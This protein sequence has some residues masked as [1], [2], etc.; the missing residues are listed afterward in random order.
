[1]WS[2]LYVKQESNELTQV[3]GK[4]EQLF[5]GNLAYDLVRFDV[6]HLRNELIALQRSVEERRDVILNLGSE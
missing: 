6:Y 1:M 4:P 2:D 3:P 5:W